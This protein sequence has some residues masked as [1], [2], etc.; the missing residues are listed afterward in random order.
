MIDIYEKI[1]EYVDEHI[2]E[3]ITIS[4]LLK[5]MG[6]SRR[7]IYKMFQEHNDVPIMEYIRKRKMRAASVE[8]LS[9]RNMYDIALDYGYETPAGFYKAFKSVFGCSPSDYKNNMLRGVIMDNQNM[10]SVEELTKEIELDASNAELYIQRGKSYLFSGQPEK[11]I[12]DYNKALELDLKNNA[13]AYRELGHAYFH[14]WQADKVIE[15]YTKAIE[16]EPNV[17]ADYF[18]RGQAYKNSNEYEKA[19]EDFTKGLKIEPEATWICYRGL[20]YFK[21]GELDKAKEDFDKA[22]E[23]SKDLGQT[24][25]QLGSIYGYD[26][27]QNDKA[28]EYYSKA[29]ELN[30]NFAWSIYGNRAAL[31]QQK[32][33]YYKA[34]EDYTK[35]IELNPK[36]DWL[37]GNRGGVYHT[38]KQYD[39]AAEDYEKAAEITSNSAS[40]A[41]SEWVYFNRANLCRDM[42]KY[43]EALEFYN[44]A[45]ELNPKASWVYSERGVIYEK[46]GE[47][48]KAEE[49]FKKAAESKS[50]KIHFYSDIGLKLYQAELYDKA[51]EYFS[52]A[53]ELDPGDVG[54][55]RM[56]YL[57]AYLNR[58]CLYDDLDMDDDALA[59]FSKSVELNIN[60]RYTGDAW[61]YWRR[62]MQYNKMKDYPRAVQDCCTALGF[63]RG[64]ASG[65]IGT[66]FDLL[67]TRAVGL[68]ELGYHEWGIEDCT[69]ALAINLKGGEE[70]ARKEAYKVRGTIYKHMKEYDKARDDYQKAL[71]LDPE[72]QEVL[73]LLASL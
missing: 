58:G 61:T 13:Q 35:A 46:L 14:L 41:N 7:H 20:C 11:A 60:W 12:E 64:E 55:D 28:L 3:E 16:L 36:A 50:N 9:D 25:Y 21:I 38:L 34:I 62:A 6:Y 2:N 49:D 15:Y 66:E 27:K 40:S 31:Y 4:D 67:V 70:V 26:L 69:K 71:E 68:G 51:I 59:D 53:I 17:S 22:L 32:H 24:Y 65:W 37:Y 48:D 56:S 73:E 8:L 54:N 1:I 44:K 47:H 19:I 18:M 72:Y 5:K 29:I 33:Q 39:K 52:K 10:K 42:K 30:S 57:R 23:V 63:Y 43:S 45:V